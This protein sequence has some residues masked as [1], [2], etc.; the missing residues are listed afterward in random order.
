MTTLHIGD[1]V[2]FRDRAYVVR[3]MSPICALLRNVQLEDAISG[4]RVNAF[5]D[6]LDEQP[7]LSFERQRAELV[8][9]GAVAE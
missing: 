5:V 4:E 1:C 9:V 6:D 2:T 8:H 3:G 7:T